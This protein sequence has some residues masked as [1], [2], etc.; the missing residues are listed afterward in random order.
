M[1]D[2]S[3]TEIARSVAS[4]ERSAEDF[5]ADALAR[6]RTHNPSINAVT[7]V[8]EDRALAEARDMDSRR[9][10]GEALPPLAGVPYVVKNLYDVEGIVTLAGSAMRQK[11]DPASQDAALIRNMKKAGA[12]LIGTTNMDEFACGFTTENTHYGTT[13]NPH[14]PDRIAGGSSGGSAAAVAAGLTPLALGTDTNGSIRVPASLSGVFGLKPTFGRLSR[15]GAFPFVASLDT[16]GPFARSVADLTLCYDALQGPDKGDPT[17]AGRPH[18]PVMPLLSLAGD[19]LRVGVLTGYFEENA[20]AEAIAARDAALEAFHSTR[21]VTLPEVERA[22]ASASIVT[23]SEG[24]MPHLG[25]LRTR[26]QEFDPLTRDRFLAGALLPAAWVHQA[27]RFRRWFLGQVL[28]IFN[29]VDILISAA[30]PWPATLIGQKEHG[31]NGNQLMV[32]RTLG[33]L[34]QP[35]SLIG[36]PAVVAPIPGEGVLPMGVQIAAAPWREDL[37]LRAASQLERSGLS[38]APLAAGFDRSEPPSKETE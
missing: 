28:D 11:C 18:E 10:R 32:A 19:D 34:T 13:R 26:P 12:V 7:A 29:D 24:A 27:Q 4:G 16:V 22:R 21:P 20:E 15:R 30:T 37:V 5:A 14:D 8:T 38:H 3:A 36:L 17:C 23:A 33:Y 35:I 2:A 31:L 9:L 6:I 1:S 25:A